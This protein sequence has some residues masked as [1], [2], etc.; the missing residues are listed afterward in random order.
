MPT[1][2]MLRENRNISKRKCFIF[3]EPRKLRKSGPLTAP[4]GALENSPR[5]KPCGTGPENA[6][7]LEGRKRALH[8]RSPT[9]PREM[10]KPEVEVPAVLAGEARGDR[11]AGRRHFSCLPAAMESQVVVQGDRHGTD[12][13]TVAGGKDESCGWF[14][15]SVTMESQN[16]PV[17]RTMPRNSSTSTGFE[18]K[19]F[20]RRW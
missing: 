20:A 9:T 17:E 6:P 4:S 18:M 16:S 19:Q 14:G 12:R 11:A 7:A 13:Y 1:E 3:A 5:R 10:Q 15:G 2:T 8:A